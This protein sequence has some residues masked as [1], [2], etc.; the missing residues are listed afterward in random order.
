MLYVNLDD[1][2]IGYLNSNALVP[3]SNKLEMQQKHAMDA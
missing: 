2:P 1:F 3:I